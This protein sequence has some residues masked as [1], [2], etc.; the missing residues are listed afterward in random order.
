MQSFFAPTCVPYLLS[1][2]DKLP[3]VIQYIEGESEKS[4]G[5]KKIR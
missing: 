1:F 2:M 5:R 4:Q 3:F